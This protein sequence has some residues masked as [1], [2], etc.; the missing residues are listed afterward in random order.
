MATIRYRGSR[1]ELMADMSRLP[2]I[3][4]GRL[5]DPGGVAKALMVAMGLVLL[6]RIK[7]AWVI[8]S[9]GG[10]D[11]MGIKWPPLAASTLQQRRVVRISEKKLQDKLA[12]LSPDR[13]ALVMAQAKQ[14]A[15][16]GGGVGKKAIAAALAEIL[17]D[18]GIMLESLGPQVVA[19]TILRTG[20][21][22][23]EV[24]SNVHYF[25]FHNSDQ[26]RRKNAD[27]TDR[28]PRRQVL[29]DNVDQIPAAWIAEMG[30]A[31]SKTMRTPEFWRL[32]LGAKVA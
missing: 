31:A 27:G 30:E 9:R 25:R 10:T 5:P 17:R 20:P 28:L 32:F 7:E 8:K 29:P 13:R 6:S 18:T 4:T 14:I 12:K 16:A 3:L 23:L 26:P 19:D 11:A 24:G 22:W 21:G 1:Q 2:G 15:A